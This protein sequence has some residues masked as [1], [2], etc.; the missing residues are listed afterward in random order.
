[1][2]TG[3]CED[4]CQERVSRQHTDIQPA[5]VLSILPA[6]AHTQLIYYTIWTSP[7]LFANHTC[8]RST[9]TFA[10]L[11]FPID[12]NKKVHHS[13][14]GADLVDHMLLKLAEMGKTTGNER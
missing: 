3:V 9:L 14:A 4:A 2:L 13:I 10:K 12:I 5:S 8:N 11:D 1:M 6:T 7:F